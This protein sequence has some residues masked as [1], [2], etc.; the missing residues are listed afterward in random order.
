[1]GRPRR[2]AAARRNAELDRSSERLGPRVLEEPHEVLPALGAD[3]EP[4]APVLLDLLLAHAQRDAA[5]RPTGDDDAPS[6][7]VGRPRTRDGTQAE[8]RESRGGKREWN[9]RAEP[10]AL[11][12]RLPWKRVASAR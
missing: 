10:K 9:L 3:Q 6:G 2:H 1:A 7:E 12:S 5:D 8:G 11:L 4:M